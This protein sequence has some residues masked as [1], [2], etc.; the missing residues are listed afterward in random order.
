MT[1]EL[2]QK[3]HLTWE[4]F[5]WGARALAK[6]LQGKHFDTIMGFP[7]GGLPLAVRLSHLLGIGMTVEPAVLSERSLVVDDI[8]DTGRSLKRF[9]EGRFDDEESQPTVATLYNTAWTE[10]RPDYWI[11]GKPGNSWVVFPWEEKE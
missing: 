4:G 2:H 8:S 5:E 6:Q 1:D 9:M 10:F 7:R 3:I 11:W